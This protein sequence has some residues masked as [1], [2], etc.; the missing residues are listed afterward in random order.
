MNESGPESFI[1]VYLLIENRLLRE[2]LERILRK[3]ASFQVVGSSGKEEC[4]P[5]RVLES[6]C[7][8]MVLDFFDASW[9]EVHLPPKAG[10]VSALKLLLIGMSDDSEQFLAAVRGGV[11]GY[12]MK[13]ASVSEVIAAVR[14]IL[15]GEAACPP[16]LCRYLFQYVSQMPQGKSVATKEGRPE[17]TLRQRQLVELVAKGL[18][19]KEIASQLNLSQYTV[20]NHVRRIMKHVD[21]GSRGQ[22]VEMILSHGY[23][24]NAGESLR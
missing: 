6:Q 13:D 16:E 22:A 1:R 15:R 11:T 9:L 24:L 8:V 2:A 14:S 3:R 17:L 7:E 4:S 5:Q 19:N 12:L 18:T 20:K 23:T 21:A 10:H